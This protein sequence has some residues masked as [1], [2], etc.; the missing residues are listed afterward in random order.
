LLWGRS[1]EE[2]EEE[3]RD[4]REFGLST[5]MGLWRIDHVG[6]E[7]KGAWASFY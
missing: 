4:K 5:W 2:E 6:G 1:E 7:K 3:A